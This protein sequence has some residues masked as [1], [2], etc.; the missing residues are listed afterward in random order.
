MQGWR[1][2]FVTDETADRLCKSKYHKLGG[3]RA[4]FA[5]VLAVMSLAFLATLA[6]LLYRFA[7]AGG[8]LVR[9]R[10]GSLA[11]IGM[12]SILIVLVIPRQRAAFRS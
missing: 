3:W 6:T 8:P 9:E 11:L 7:M 5:A 10:N 1:M 2:E 4:V 12:F